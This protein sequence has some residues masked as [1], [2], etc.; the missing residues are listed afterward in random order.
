VFKEKGSER[1]SVHQTLER[2]AVASALTAE[3]GVRAR[4]FLALR[5]DGKDARCAVAQGT[6]TSD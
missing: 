6:T 4:T 1:N 5:R 3:G 2:A